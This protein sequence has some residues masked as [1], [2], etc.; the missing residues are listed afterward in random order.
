MPPL[1]RDTSE[2]LG[3]VPKFGLDHTG[4]LGVGEGNTTPGPL[5]FPSVYNPGFTPKSD[6][7][8]D[9]SKK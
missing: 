3:V 1:H 6:A 9:T 2:L 5:E 7:V 4:P 8:W